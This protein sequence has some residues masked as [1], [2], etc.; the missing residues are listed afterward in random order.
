MKRLAAILFAAVTWA[1]LAHGDPVSVLFVGNSYT[2]ARI[3]PAM[4]Y[5]AANVNDLTAAFNAL[6]PAGTNSFPVGSGI[7][8]SPCVTAGTGCFEP[9]P[10][11]GVP[12][13]FKK[14]TDQAGLD[15]DVSH[16]TRNAASLRG[17]FLQTSNSPPWK[18]REN[19]A[20]QK[21]DVVILQEQSD[22]ALPPG[23]G[24]NA[25]LATFNAYADQF[26]R[27]IHTGDVTGPDG[28]YTET[29]LFGSLTACRA[30]GLST[31]SCN[32]PRPIALN[33]NA[34]P[35]T[36]VYLQQT[37]ARPDMVEAH[38]C[39]KADVTTMDGAPIVDS[40]C[41]GTNPNGN[42]ATGQNFL[43][44]TSQPTTPANLADMT[45]D[46]HSSFYG[47][48]TTNPNFAG[49]APV[50]DAFQ[51]AVNEG[52]AKG[53]GFYNAGGTYDEPAAPPINLWWIDRTHASKYG[54]YL[55]ALVL[56]QTIT[57]RNP[58]SLGSGEQAAAD[59]GIAPDVAVQL[60]R[61]AQAT[62]GPDLS[63][64]TTV[65]AANPPAN[66][67]GWNNADVTVTLAATDNANGS[68]VKQIAFAT[69]SAQVGTGIVN[70]DSASLIIS[71]EGETTVTYYATDNAGNVEAAKTLVV[72]LDK[73]PPSLS[74]M[75]AAGCEIWPPN[76]KLVNVATVVAQN[77]LSGLSSFN[78][79]VASS[80]PAA[81]GQSD[82]VTT[83]TGLAPR[84]IS[85]RATRLG[86]GPGRTYTISA[87]ATD[88]AGNAATAVATCVVPHDRGQ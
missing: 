80:E 88:R 14:M 12:G 45:A 20:L 59:L 7:P 50:G 75:P 79:N 42:P 21:W 61:I 82:T 34:N 15:Y 76:N 69:T 86:N 30:T 36:K 26:E 33:P 39:T 16:S 62:V 27:F 78:T 43:Y 41:G 56:F 37:W 84:T 49:V 22:A 68:G 8:P 35:A 17:Q 83:G 81:P 67:N 46:L 87:S 54:S 23:K 73:T 32:L 57:G 70:G 60:Q 19:V 38:K 65:A 31:T 9:H 77:G 48:A 6:Q 13:I 44:Y 40:T 52:F 55:S 11:G 4:Q 3:A 2:F 47:K 10:W 29:E 53:S 28:V 74:G 24:K 5:N 72:Q 1:P 85:V 71:A 58:L 25:D 18:L 51:R 63:T 64:P 66:A